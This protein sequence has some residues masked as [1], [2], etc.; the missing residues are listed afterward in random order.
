[1]CEFVRDMLEM[2]AVLTQYSA[3]TTFITE[4]Q[5]QHPSCP[6]DPRMD[7]NKNTENEHTQY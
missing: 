7:G 6:W 5:P 3:V 4:T 1:M 2:V